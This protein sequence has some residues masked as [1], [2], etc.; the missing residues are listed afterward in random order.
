MLTHSETADTSCASPSWLSARLLTR[1]LRVSTVRFVPNEAAIS[2][3]AAPAVP[4]PM[5]YDAHPL[6]SVHG[7]SRTSWPRA[8]SGRVSP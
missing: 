7:A 6:R 2:V 3:A 8:L 5:N 4:L 1:G